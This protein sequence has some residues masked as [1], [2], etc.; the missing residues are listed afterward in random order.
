MASVSLSFPVA[1]LA[2]S[3]A[4]EKP[5]ELFKSGSNQIQHAPTFFNLPSR[6]EVSGVECT[7]V[8]V[9]SPCIH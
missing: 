5:T 4:Y 9:T 6:F 2:A 7:P 8:F 3:M 1:F